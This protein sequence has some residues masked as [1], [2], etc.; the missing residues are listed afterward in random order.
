MKSRN[1]D[2]EQSMEEILA[3]IRRIISEDDKNVKLDDVIDLHP[4]REPLDPEFT[5]IK[6]DENILH[7]TED[8]LEVTSDNSGTEKIISDEISAEVKN[9]FDILSKL[10]TPDY[11]G[12]DAKIDTLV[13]DLLRPMLKQWLEKNL[14]SL[15]KKMVSKEISRLIETKKP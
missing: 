1:N 11:K 7:L 2:E 6:I 9:Q 10:L 14:P 3:S 15:V 4:N 12:A 8:D 5:D 13:S